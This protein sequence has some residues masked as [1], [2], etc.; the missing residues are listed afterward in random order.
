GKYLSDKTPQAVWIVRALRS[1]TGLDFKAKTRAALSSDESH[2]LDL[3]THHR[4]RFFGTWM[5]RDSTW[6]APED[7]QLSI[8]K[9]WREWFA[10][11]GHNYKY[12][13]NKD[14]DDWYF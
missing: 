13:N 5:S 8:I 2:F 10:Q 7:A 11:H 3:D 12:P 4:V 9:Q 14:F 6:V 1:L